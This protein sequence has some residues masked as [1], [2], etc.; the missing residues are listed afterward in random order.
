MPARKGYLNP[1][2]ERAERLHELGLDWRKALD[3][4]ANA[5]DEP[6]TSISIHL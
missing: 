6:C 4:L 1:T 2:L 5:G 3:H